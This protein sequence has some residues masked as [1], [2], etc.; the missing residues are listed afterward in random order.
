[1]T[2]FYL[3]FSRYV[4]VLLMLTTTMAWS[5][6]RN[7]TG[8]V[9]ASDDGSAMPGVNIVVKGTSTGT[10]TDVEGRYSVNVD[11]NAT[12]VFTFVGY[13]SQEV[14]VGNQSEVNVTLQ[15]DITSLSEVVV[16]GYGA[17]KKKDLT[18]SVAQVGAADFNKGIYVSPGQLLQGKIA[19]VL[20]TGS[21]GAPG[22]EVS[23]RIRGNSSI[24]GGNSPLI[25]VD[26][27][28]LDN[29][30]A[31]TSINVPGGLGNTPGIDPLSF[32]N[33]NDIETFD[34]LKDASAT[35][36]YGSRGSNGVIM[37]T[38]KKGQGDRID[39]S[40][41]TGVSTLSKKLDVMTAD[42]YVS[43]LQTEEVAV[44]DY[45][46]S[47][48][49]FDKII[50]TGTMQNYNI[51]F[52]TGNE[53]SS[54][55]LSLGY[56]DQKGIIKESGL[57]KFN[58][59]LRS[60]YNFFDNRIKVDMLVLGSNVNQTSAP[61][62]NNSST[63]G[64]LISQAL[65]WN[66]TRDLYDIDGKF[67]QPGGV[68]V[69]PLALLKAY[70][71]KFIMNR[72]IASVAPTIQILK[73]LDYRVQVGIDHTQGDRGVSLKKFL[74]VSGQPNLGQA[75]FNSFQLTT[76]QITQTLSWNKEMGSITLNALAGYEFQRSKLDGIS[77][78]A[79]G[80]TDDAIDFVKSLQN[81][82]AANTGMSYTAPPDT[83]L[84]SFFGRANL[85]FSDKF[86]FTATVRADGS[87]RFGA[88]NRY[89]VFPALAVAWNL[90]ES[91]FLPQSINTAKL[92]LGWGLTGNQQFPA[93]SSLDRW[94]FA[95]GGGTGTISQAN[96]GNP[97]LKWETTTT[98]NAGLDFGLFNSRVTGSID[99][100]NRTTNDIL[101]NV[102]TPQ[103]G[104]A[105]SYWTNLDAEIHNT[106]LELGLNTYIIDKE[107]LKWQFG[108]NVTF[109]KNKYTSNNDV[110]LYTGTINGKGLSG[111]TSQV[112]APNEALNAF[113]L[114]T[115]TGIG[116]DG[117]STY[118]GYDEISGSSPRTVVG[119]PNPNVLLGISTSVNV[120]Q[121]DASL[122]FNG[123]FGHQI[124]NNTANAVFVKGNLGSRNTSKDLIGNGESPG[125]VSAASTRYLEDGDF[126]RL[127]NVS[128]GYTISPSSKAIKNLRF[129]VTGQNLLL[130]T[131]YSGF[132]PEV[133]TDKNSNGVPS[134]GIEYTPYPRAR[135]F[136]IG[137]SASF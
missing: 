99:Y 20:V 52:S 67:V 65:Q 69:N 66:P 107:N 26:G 22:A 47:V 120:K 109:L 49:A 16:V 82:T 4:T 133:N 56:T 111:V 84:Q 18:G 21:S 98:I 62:G 101:F 92:R 85:N 124:Y 45:G 115:W 135:T 94:S 64:N 61:I 116:E 25:V 86:L 39:F 127:A 95:S 88:N 91:N 32:I 131:K 55:R 100:F 74:L 93:G 112:I 136:I 2:K 53:R 6:S 42:E 10:T 38:T 1:M 27:M 8:K 102:T 113:Y 128:L 29:G 43:A 57:K 104:P 87:S 14:S 106:G 33:P 19:G 23:I 83:K 15:S 11:D 77:V 68:E 130:F 5:Q 76:E 51:G 48:N 34:V 28:Q 80:F 9:T 110:V 81:A 46:S 17:V 108:T 37:I 3:S 31:K 103:P 97:N 123:A 79:T 75:Y 90:H 96:L 89:G 7:V 78:S 71:D 24:R 121:F 134:Y 44:G 122:N 35:A 58:A 41:S 125:N 114:R 119:D 117:F 126:L 50:Q 36:I 40:A 13:T 60:S 105:I 30:S 70:D 72:V 129:Y 63:D 73:G 132:D 54:H 12:L 59:M 137:V 118:Q